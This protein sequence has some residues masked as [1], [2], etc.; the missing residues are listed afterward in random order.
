MQKNSFAHYR[1]NF[2][3]VFK[4]AVKFVDLIYG[5]NRTLDVA[6]VSLAPSFVLGRNQGRMNEVRVRI[7]PRRA[8]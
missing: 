4:S 7:A 2:C 5:S 8:G 3:G 6:Q 1:W